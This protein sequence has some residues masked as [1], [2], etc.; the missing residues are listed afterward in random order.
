MLANDVNS[1]FSDKLMDWT[2]KV[3]GVGGGGGGGAGGGHSSSSMS[4][5]DLL[6]DAFSNI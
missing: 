2:G 3:G 5:S 6:K 1:A 4:T